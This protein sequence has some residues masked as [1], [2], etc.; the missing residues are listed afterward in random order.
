MATKI[1]DSISR[2]RNLIK[3]VKEDAFI[4]DR[5][6]YSL[7]LKYSK[8]MIRR[9]DNENKI[10]RFQSLFETVPCVELIEIDKVEACCG[11]I[12]TNCTIKRTKDKIPT[13]MEGT[14]G[15]LIRSITSIDRS[16]NISRTYPTIYTSIANSKNNKYNTVKYYWYSDGHL[17]FPNIEWDAVLVEAMWEESIAYLKCDDKEQCVIR[18]DEVMHIPEYLFADIEQMSLKDLG[19]FIQMPNETQDD[20]QSI[21]RS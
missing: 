1:G 17:Y 14:Y 19:I 13:I 9:Q 6:L 3:A 12:K 7:I 10:M 5:F 16:I 15:P 11:G 4:T 20:K 18:Q 2:L 8:L 21:L